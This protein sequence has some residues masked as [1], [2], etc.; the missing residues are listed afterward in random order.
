LGKQKNHGTSDG[1]GSSA[2]YCAKGINLM[3]SS[4]SELPGWPAS[5]ALRVQD[6]E[7]Y[8]S[9]KRGISQRRRGKVHKG[10][11]EDAFDLQNHD[12]HFQQGKS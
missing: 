12:L 1:K 9:Y 2:E 6:Y 5:E 4:L 10:L 7:R 3:R 11:S 8:E